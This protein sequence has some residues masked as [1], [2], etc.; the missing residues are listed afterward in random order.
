MKIGL[1]SH[2]G[3]EDRL[4]FA[5]QIGAHGASIWG[6]TLPG[7]REKGYPTLDG[8]LEMRERFARYNLEMT[9]IG[10][11]GQVV[12]NQLLGCPGRER[13]VENVCRTIQVMGEAYRDTAN[14]P[15]VIIDQRITY[16]VREG[17][18][19]AA[20]LPIGRGGALLYSFDISRGE[21]D[22]PAGQVS[23]AE[24]WE[25]MAYLYERIVPVAEESHIRLATH[26]DDPPM[27]YYRGVHQ[28]LTGFAGFR[29]FI[30]RFPS[31]YNGLLL[32]L[33]C[34]QEA[35]ENVPEVIRYFGNRRKIFYVHFRN[36]RGRVPRYEEVFPNEGEM[37][38]I[39]AFRAL[40]EV[41][42]QDYLVADHHVGLVGDTEWAHMSQAWHVG[43]LTGLLQTLES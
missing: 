37:D 12:K 14:S 40:K 27:S 16:W 4:K 42:Y 25:R 35:G 10:L 20:R 31:P 39:A 9:G 38:A 15:V 33:G 32:C 18:T 8:L 21:M 2:D 24:V 17:F 7:Y 41:G 43:Y 6:E 19:G 36:V 28:V 13:D 29:E 3:A 1:R 5:Q 22:A 34:M 30:E 26:P 23:S 11:G